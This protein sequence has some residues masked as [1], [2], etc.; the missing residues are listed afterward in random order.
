MMVRADEE[1]VRLRW[2]AA[3]RPRDRVMNGGDEA[4]LALVL[5]AGGLVGGEL[6]RALPAAGWRVLAASHA[7][8]DIRNVAQVR[9]ACGNG[10]PSSSTPPPTPTSI[11]PSPSPMPRGP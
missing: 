11:A 10:P 2:P 3:R 5:G 1:D 4:P 9:A 8:C 6:C 7:D